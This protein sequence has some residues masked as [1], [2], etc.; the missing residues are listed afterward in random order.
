MKRMGLDLSRSFG[1]REGHEGTGYYREKSV[2]IRIMMKR[3]EG[4]GERF[5]FHERT[6]GFAEQPIAANKRIWQELRLKVL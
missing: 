1:E 6:M 4:G 2:E 5:E 3:E